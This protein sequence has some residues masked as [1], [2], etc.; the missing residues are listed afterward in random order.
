MHPVGAI[1]GDITYV[2]SWWFLDDDVAASPSELCTN[3][4]GRLWPAPDENDYAR[5]D[6]G[7][8]PGSMTVSFCHSKRQG[9]PGLIWIGG[10]VA[11]RTPS[12]AGYY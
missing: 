4:V 8:V 12:G 1:S 2:P 11:Q 7:Y 5:F 3:R 10:A 6:T 9:Y